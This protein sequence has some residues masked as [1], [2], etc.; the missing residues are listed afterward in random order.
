MAEILA[1]LSLKPAIVMYHGIVG[2]FCRSVRLFISGASGYIGCTGF[3][4]PRLSIVADTVLSDALVYLIK[5]FIEANG[6]AKPE[7]IIWY[8]G[9]CSE[10]SM[11]SILKN[12]CEGNFSIQSSALIGNALIGN[13]SSFFGKLSLLS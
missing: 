3:Q 1:F 7:R 10:G 11:Q 9:G 12:E 2:Q 4:D 13:K 6:G 5:Q 8:R